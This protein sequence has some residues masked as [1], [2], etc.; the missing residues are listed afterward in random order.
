MKHEPSPVKQ[1]A[2][3]KGQK[4]H[5]PANADDQPAASRIK[6]DP[7]SMKAEANCTESS[8]QQAA[9]LAIAL[10]L[11]PVAAAQPD[12]APAAAP[13]VAPAPVAAP[14]AAAP[15]ATAAAP[16]TKPKGRGKGRK[17]QPTKRQIELTHP[18]PAEPEPIAQYPQDF[19][20]DYKGR[21]VRLRFNCGG[22]PVWNAGRIGDRVNKPDL[23]QHVYWVWYWKDENN[24]G[25]PKLEPGPRPCALEQATYSAQAAPPLGSWHVLEEEE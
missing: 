25:V 1:E 4:R 13:V 17:K 5:A 7:D 18:P 14:R 8:A 22:K 12:A 2:V 16:K 3:D 11:E 9:H 21:F 6:T 15:T 24:T 23:G 19:G 10:D 20:D